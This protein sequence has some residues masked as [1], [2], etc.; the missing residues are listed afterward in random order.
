MPMPNS[1]NTPLFKGQGIQDFLDMLEAL[2]N[3]S[4]VDVNNLPAYILCY[5]QQHIC[6]VI[7]GAPHWNKNDWPMTHACLIK[8]Y[9]S[10]DCQPH[11][12]PNKFTK[13]IKHHSKTKNFNSLQDVNRYLRKFMAQST[14]LLMR[15]YYFS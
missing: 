14:P 7:E 5:C 2:T 8:L 3:S 9:S 10:N 13:W 4:L 12:S 15:L 11:V 6:G 1:P